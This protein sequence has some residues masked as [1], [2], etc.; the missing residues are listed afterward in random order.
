MQGWCSRLLY[1]PFPGAQV[2]GDCRGCKQ[3]IHGDQL[4]DNLPARSMKISEIL[5]ITR[6]DLR[7]SGS[8]VLDLEITRVSPL[9]RAVKGEISFLSNPRHKDAV[10]TTKASAVLVREF[11]SD[12]YIPQIIVADPYL[13]MAEIAGLLHRRTKT[14]PSQGSLSYIDPQA[15]ID[16]QA[17]VY[18]FVFIGANSRVGKHS[19]IYPHCFIDAHV[20]IGA[21][22]VINPRVT[23]H[24]NCHIGDNVTIHAGTVIG[25]DGFGFAQTQTEAV[26]I[27]HTGRIIIE[28]NCEIGA[29]NTIARAT[30]AETR[31]RTGTKLDAQ[32][33][34]AHNVDLGRFSLIAAQSG[35]AGSTKV[36]DKLIMGGQTGIGPG[37]N[38]PSHIVL[39]ARGGL[40]KQVSASGQYA[41]S[42]AIPASLWRR[43]QVALKALPDLLSRLKKFLRT[44][45]L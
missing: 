33:H 2:L 14:H 29:L 1:F 42:P 40:A 7:E 32:V 37:L 15:H 3:I 21:H 39:G 30:F 34:I 36:G 26:K 28:D 6:G 35:I 25:C 43:Q 31:I 20:E 44:N 41:G 4:F 5:Q 16:P 9:D 12:L 22:T 24:D 18:P 45:V 23:I 11:L 19:V 27:P 13:A 17:I 8:D 38:L 10:F